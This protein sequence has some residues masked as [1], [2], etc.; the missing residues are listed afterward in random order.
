MKGRRFKCQ[1]T[2]WQFGAE[3]QDPDS[4][5]RLSLLLYDRSQTP[6]RIRNVRLIP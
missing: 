2:N 4:V 3:L 1:A 6:L 5:A